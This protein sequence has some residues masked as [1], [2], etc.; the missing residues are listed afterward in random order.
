MQSENK[1]REKVFNEIWRLCDGRMMVAMKLMVPQ[2]YDT[3]YAFCNE[4]VP[5][6]RRAAVLLEKLLPGE[7]PDEVQET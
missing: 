1:T 3:P 2:L 4:D 5:Y 7:L 6:V